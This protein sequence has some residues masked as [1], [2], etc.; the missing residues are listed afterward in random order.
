LFEIG[1]T[2]V[3]C[4]VEDSSNNK[5]EKSF[6]I[7]VTFVESVEL[8]NVPPPVIVSPQ[9]GDN[10]TIDCEGGINTLTGGLGKDKFFCGSIGDTISDFNAAEDTKSGKCMLSP[11]LTGGY[12]YGPSLSLSGKN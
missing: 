4:K 9:D 6:L 1:V 5:V 8:F 2:E 11:A 10:F 3:N 12:N 7:K